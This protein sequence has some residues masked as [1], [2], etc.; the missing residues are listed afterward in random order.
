MWES[1][2]IIILVIGLWGYVNNKRN[3]FRL[4]I[5]LEILLIS[6]TV[7]L[8]I[9]SLLLDDKSGELFGI[10]VISVAGCESAIGLSILVSYFRSSGNVVE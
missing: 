6:S 5:A 7:L 9:G 2:V 10:Y 4:F 8:I 3:L 1:S